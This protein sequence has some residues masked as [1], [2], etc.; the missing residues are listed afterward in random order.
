MLKAVPVPDMPLESPI[1]WLINAL[2]PLASLYHEDHDESTLTNHPIFPASDD[3]RYIGRF[4]YLLELS[5]QKYD[6]EQMDQKA[7]ALLQL[8]LTVAASAPPSP[9]EYL[10]SYLLPSYKDQD[11]V[12]GTG[13]SLPARLLR[14]STSPAT[15]HLR[16]LIP[17]IFFELSDQDE[18]KL[19]RNIGYGFAAGFL[20]SR[21]SRMPIPG[22]ADASNTTQKHKASNVASSGKDEKDD[23]DNL[24]EV[25]PVTGQRRDKEPQVDLPEMSDEEKEREAERLFVLFE[26]CVLDPGDLCRMLI[27]IRLR[28]TGVV[29]A[30]NPVETAV[31]EGRFEEL[32]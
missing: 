1:C 14:L 21:R 5:A 32:E 8:I 28:A 26:R 20:L 4:V 23:N 18:E 24:V 15:R 29:D 3:S 12:L 11:N 13:D 22:T 31:Q 19:V 6:E 17:A 10:Q 27:G 16:E 25:N 30:R 9:K 2:L 7:A